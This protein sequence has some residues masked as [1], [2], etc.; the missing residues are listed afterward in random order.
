MNTS[1][2]SQIYLHVRSKDGTQLTEGLN[3]H[4]SVNLASAITTRPD[5]IIHISL[6][7][8]SIPHSFYPVSDRLKN[9]TITYDDTETLTLPSQNYDPYELLKV[10]NSD[11]AF[12]AIFTASY[13]EFTNKLVLTN[14]TVDTHTLNWTLSNSE[15]ILGF[16]N[17]TDDIV[18]AGQ[19]TTSNGMLDFASI[20]SVILRS[21]IAQGNVLS[22]NTGQSSILQK[23]NIDVAPYGMIF[24]N[25]TDVS[26]VSLSSAPSIEQITFQLQ[27]QNNNL[28]DFNDI[29]Y[30]FS[31]LFTIHEMSKPTVAKLEIDTRRDGTVLESRASISKPIETTVVNPKEII[32]EG[33][34]TRNI[35]HVVSE[36]ILDL[37]L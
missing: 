3:S 34:E 22:T 19:S 23:I 26:Q 21:S 5:Q 36:T 8:A 37:F 25:A 10:L 32:S 29:N 11:T 17:Q 14:T 24:L 13:E 9:D 6:I 7:S 35:D 16:Y 15:K 2:N 18:L 30:E 27:D 1:L 33:P 20:H 31:L 4:F 12:N 28:I